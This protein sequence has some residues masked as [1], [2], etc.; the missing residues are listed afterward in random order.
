MD[1][2]V[3]YSKSYV[4]VSLKKNNGKC[5]LLVENDTNGIEKGNLDKVFE[6]FYR[7]DESRNNEIKGFGIV[8]SIAKSIAD[9]HGAKI[10]AS[11]EDGIIFKMTTTF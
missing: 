1:N 4:N 6:R 11:S 3:K 7:L 8:L 5:I 2:A 10:N 9:S